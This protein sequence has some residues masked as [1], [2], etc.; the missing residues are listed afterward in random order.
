MLFKKAFDYLKVG[1]TKFGRFLDEKLLKPLDEALFGENGLFTKF[2]ETEF[3]KD[4]KEFFSRLTT[5]VSTFLFGEKDSEGNRSGGLFSETW[6]SLKSIGSDVKVAILGEKGPDGKP[7]PLDQ[8]TSILGN[9]KRLFYNTTDNIKSALGIDTSDKNETFGAKFSRGLDSIY[10]RIKERSAE[11][12]KDLF[13]NF[14]GGKE[15]ADQFREDLKGQKGF[16]GASAVIG[17][18]G[19]VTL[20]GHMGILGSLFLPSGLIGG[21]ILG[22]GIG[23]ASKS[24]AIKNFL[25]GPEEN[26][27]RQGGLFTKEFQKFFKDNKT[28]IGWGAG[29]GLA[30]SFGLIPYLW[31]PGG[32]IGGALIGGA[33][34]MVSKSGAFSNFLYGEGGTKDNPTGGLMA[35]FK[36]LFGKDKS[37]KGLAIDGAIGAGVGLLGSFFLPGGPMLGAILGGAASIGLASERFK[38]WFFG[39]KGDDGQRSGG[40]LS[41]F[42]GYMKEHVFLPLFKATQ[43][44]QVKILGFVRDQM[45]TPFMWA[46]RPII[47]EAKYIGSKISDMAGAVWTS[48]KTMFSKRVVK[49][50]GDTI[51]RYFLKPLRSLFGTIF[52]TLGTVVGA[53]ISSPFKLITALGKAAY[54]RQ[55]ERGARAYDKSIGT[56]TWLGK[57]GN[58]IR[59]SYQ[60][61]RQQRAAR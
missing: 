21:A 19:A 50:I 60:E 31:M 30:S 15:F 6:N 54:N 48:V 26:G 59:T 47:E 37:L 18:I 27:E 45:V 16:V 55:Q 56:D 35:K 17:G 11:F 52:R 9:L 20:S 46:M 10:T 44:A 25:F 49:P 33:L 51:E 43:V 42:T 24:T 5:N 53:I 39:T 38:T 61:R 36:S 13:G 29:I 4:T 14:K 58:L 1:F 40:A 32:P 57:L 41:R 28:G 2:K 3:W 12:T 23:I 34:S 22:A 8:D 7:L